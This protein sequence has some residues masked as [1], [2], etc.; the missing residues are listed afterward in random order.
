MPDRS[1]HY[2]EPLISLPSRF[3]DNDRSFLG[4]TDWSSLIFLRLLQALTIISVGSL[5]SPARRALGWSRPSNATTVDKISTIVQ[6]SIFLLNLP[7]SISSCSSGS[8][9]WR[10]AGRGRSGWRRAGDWWRTSSAGGVDG[11]GGGTS[12]LVALSGHDL[13][14]PCSE[15]LCQKLVKSL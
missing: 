8:S 13:V 1:K 6:H 12:A 5:A 15:V 4:R 11:D 7:L 9:G 3:V 2:V 14:V 10:R